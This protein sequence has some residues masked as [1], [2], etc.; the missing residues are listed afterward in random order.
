MG[1][2]LHPAFYRAVQGIIERGRRR[3]VAWLALIVGMVLTAGHAQTAW[4]GLLLAGAYA[5]WCVLVHPQG[6]PP[7]RPYRRLV[8]ALPAV[9]LGAGLAAMQ[10]AATADLLVNSQR[11]DS[12][13]EE[14]AAFN[15]SYAPLRIPNFIAPN[16]YGNPGDGSYL[17]GG[18]FY[19]EAVYVGLVPLVAAFT[20]M[21]AF[22]GRLF[23]R[24]RDERRYVRDVPFWFAV[25]VVAFVFALG[26]H[27]PVFPFLYRNVPTF[28]MFQAPGRWHIITVFALSVLAG[29]GVAQWGA[30]KWVIFW[31][32]LTT[33][34]AVGAGLLAVLSPQFLPPD[35]LVLEGVQVLTQ[36]VMM[37]ALWVA[38]AGV[39]TLLYAPNVPERFLP[40]P[41]W[42]ST[43]WALLVLVVVG[44]DLGWATRGLNP[45]VPAAFYNPLEGVDSDPLYRAYWPEDDLNLL[46]YGQRETEDGALET[47]DPEELGFEP[48]LAGNDYRIA[49]E[50]WREF[51]ELPLPNMNLLDRL[52]LLNNF[53]PLLLEQFADL[54]EQVEAADDFELLEQMA[55]DTVYTVDE[56]IE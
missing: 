25:F 5:V 16:V 53:D 21:F 34:G 33:A 54:V 45:T 2:G 27:T 4:Y 17:P 11:S 56:M 12:F 35:T 38:L 47:V 37:T 3:D 9:I 14:Q 55:V 36:Q 44:A 1:R 40:L 28:D 30:G 39:L 6:D 20:A 29:V 22:I 18:L 50:N 24:K 23:T 43:A 19:E 8:Y 46:L 42:Y 52:Y 31:T 13:G 48:W 7:G 32:R 51:R 49:Q 41:G 15:F 10:L 26:R